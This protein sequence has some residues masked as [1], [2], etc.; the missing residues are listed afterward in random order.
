M[1]QKPILDA[2]YTNLCKDLLASYE[3]RAKRK[4]KRIPVCP[5][6]K[7]LSNIACPGKS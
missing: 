5:W 7:E 6:D 2:V 3:Y 1:K 4:K